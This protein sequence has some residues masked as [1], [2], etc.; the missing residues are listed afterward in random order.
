[1][2]AGSD[3]SGRLLVDGSPAFR[4]GDGDGGIE[5]PSPCPH[6]GVGAPC[7]GKSRGFPPIKLPADEGS[8]PTCTGAEAIQD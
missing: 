6:G 5:A 2:R 1:M 3:W 7:P 8:P 4:L